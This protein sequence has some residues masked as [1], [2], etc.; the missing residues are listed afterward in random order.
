MGEPRLLYDVCKDWVEAQQKLEAL[1]REC[2]ALTGKPVEAA[3]NDMRRLLAPIDDRPSACPEYDGQPE[4]R[5]SH[6]QEPMP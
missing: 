2:Y 1:D 6:V 3:M 4:I 5:T